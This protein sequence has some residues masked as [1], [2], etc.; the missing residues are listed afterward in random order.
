[1]KDKDESI[2]SI[3][4]PELRLLKTI[5]GDAKEEYAISF[6]TTSLCMSF[7]NPCTSWHDRQVRA[8]VSLQ[9]VENGQQRDMVKARCPYAVGSH[10]HRKK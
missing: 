3:Q 10:Q 6:T 7:P 1:M 2:K 5:K 4:T 8:C 9:S